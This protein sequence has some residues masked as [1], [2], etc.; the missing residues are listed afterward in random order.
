MSYKLAFWCHAPVAPSVYIPT[1]RVQGFHCLHILAN[2]FVYSH[3]TRVRWYLIQFWFV[4]PWLCNIEH[5]V[6]YLLVIGLCWRN[7][8]SSPF[9]KIYL[10]ISER[11]RREREHVSG[12][13]GTGKGK[14]SQSNTPLSTEPDVGLNLMIRRSW[15]EPK[16]RIRRSTDWTTQVPLKLFIN[17]VISGFVCLFVL[18]SCRSFL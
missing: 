5:L 10:F 9:F 12:E 17:Q 18:R 4:F 3:S 6:I 15:P 7:V 16:S 14:E 11:E 1:N 2:T 13:R 8:Y